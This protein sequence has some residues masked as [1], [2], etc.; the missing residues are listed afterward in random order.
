MA[1]VTRDG[2]DALFTA[3][4]KSPIFSSYSAARAGPNPKLSCADLIHASTPLC[5]G[6][7]KAWM[8]GTCPA[9][10]KPRGRFPPLSDRKF[11]P[12]QPRARGEG[13]VRA[14]RAW[15][16]FEDTRTGAMAAVGGGSYLFSFRVSGPLGNGGG[17]D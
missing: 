13:E 8:A 4:L 6:R 2:A 16:R 15:G 5:F 7:S 3:T 17:T 14:E 10:T 11:F 12:G 1:V 9:K